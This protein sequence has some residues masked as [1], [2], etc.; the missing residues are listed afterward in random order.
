MKNDMQPILGL[1]AYQQINTV[2]ICILAGCL[3]SKL[4]GK[5]RINVEKGHK[6]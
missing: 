5:N 6:L 2:I 1:A 4:V 3:D